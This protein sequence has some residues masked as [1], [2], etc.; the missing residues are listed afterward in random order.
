MTTPLRMADSNIPTVQ[1]PTAI[2]R[3]PILSSTPFTAPL[4]TTSDSDTDLSSF[5]LE[6]TLAHLVDFLVHKLEAIYPP[7]F[8][9][10]LRNSIVSHLTPKLAPTWDPLNPSSGS[11]VRSLIALPGKFPTPLVKAAQ[12]VGIDPVKWTRA[13]SETGEWEIW[14]DPGSVCFREGGWAFAD[15]AF[16][17]KMYKREWLQH[18]PLCRDRLRGNSRRSRLTIMVS[19]FDLAETL[20]T[21]WHAPLSIETSDDFDPGDSEDLPS[22]PASSSSTSMKRSTLPI[23]APAVFRIP[24]SPMPLVEGMRSLSL[25]AQSDNN[26]KPT[27]GIATSTSN[28]FDVGRPMDNGRLGGGG[29]GFMN[30]AGGIAMMAGSAPLIKRSLPNQTMDSSSSASPFGSASASGPGWNTAGSTRSTPLKGKRIAPQVVAMPIGDAAVGAGRRSA[31]PVL[32]SSLARSG[33]L[34][35]MAQTPRSI[36]LG[37]PANA[38]DLLAL[39]NRKPEPLKDEQI[40]FGKTHAAQP[41]TPPR[42]P[43]PAFIPDTPGSVATVRPRSPSSV[44][45]T[46][47]TATSAASSSPRTDTTNS[48]GTAARVQ[49]YDGGNVGVL[50]GGVKLGGHGVP[51]TPIVGGNRS[52]SASGTS[53]LSGMSGRRTVSGSSSV[54]SEEGSPEHKTGL[55]SPTPVDSSPVGGIVHPHQPKRRRGRPQ[56]RPYFGGASPKGGLPIQPGTGIAGQPGSGTAPMGPPFQY[57]QNMPYGHGQMP[58]GRPGFGS[59]QSGPAQ[60][61]PPVASPGSPGNIPPPPAWNNVGLVNGLP[62]MAPNPGGWGVNPAVLNAVAPPIGGGVPG[63][64]GT[65]Y[66]GLQQHQHHQRS[67]H[68]HHQ[69]QHQHQ[70]QNQQLNHSPNQNRGGP[71]MNA[72]VANAAGINVAAWNLGVASGMITQPQSQGGPRRS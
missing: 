24:S 37:T 57:Q 47:G 72:H 27:T 43:G 2:K 52:R 67:P 61:V 68:H 8:V 71:H 45:A 19:L 33:H 70:H 55:A 5:S 6:T 63:Q 59:P 11:G 38:S 48:P 65:G 36:S 12:E 18:S 20:H 51:K 13:I 58:V 21:V 69:N 50:G 10:A 22:V 1:A 28:P 39:L 7:H 41:R 4:R 42:A 15:D 31:S 35:H 44:I 62:A 14:V 25:R 30:S 23:R 40:S 34:A 3:R 64:P 49:G 60:P 16:E 26:N 66:H 32:P 17:N 29:S 46:A 53:V 56:N 54:I 9:Q